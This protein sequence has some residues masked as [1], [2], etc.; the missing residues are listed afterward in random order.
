LEVL[1]TDAFTEWLESLRDRQ[2]RSKILARI[3]RAQAG[4]LGSTKALGGKVAEMKIDH[5][6]G[7]RVYFT[8]RGNMTILLLGG[9]D[10]GTQDA[11]IQAAKNLVK[12]LDD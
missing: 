11:D 3:T 2:A 6:P 4:N 7:Y 9:G 10:K 1:Q 12:E 5:G 8:R